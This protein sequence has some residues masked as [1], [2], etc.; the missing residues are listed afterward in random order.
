MSGRGDGRVRLG[1]IAAAGCDVCDRFLRARKGVAAVE[2]A[3]ILPIMLGLYFGLTELSRA[4]ANGRK[5]SLLSRTI[6]DLVARDSVLTTAKMSDIFAAGGAVL[7]PFNASG[8]HI[9]V[10]AVGVYKVGSNFQ[11]FICSSSASNALVRPIGLPTT[12]FPAVPDAFK[13]NGMRYV[14]TE[15]TMAYTPILGQALIT[16]VSNAAGSIGF[17]EQTAWPVRGGQIYPGSSQSEVVLPNLGLPCPLT[18]P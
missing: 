6:S 5:V 4:L 18:L 14:L 2:F 11:A 15:I 10:S 7:A 9:R 13:Q 3:L 17:T 1:Q 16:F 8:A 12:D